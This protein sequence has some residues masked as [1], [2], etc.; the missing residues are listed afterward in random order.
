EPEPEPVA[1]T[2]TEPEPEPVAEPETEPEPVAETEPEPV[3]ETEP[4][5]GTDTE[6]E[7]GRLESARL[8]A[9]PIG[10]APTTAPR[11][12]ES[13][14][15]EDDAA[16]LAASPPDEGGQ[17]PL[18]EV[19]EPA[20][21]NEPDAV[22]DVTTSETDDILGGVPLPITALPDAEGGCAQVYVVG[23]VKRC[24][25]CG[26]ETRVIAG[27]LVN[28]PS[29]VE[30]DPSQS[31]P[32][33]RNRRKASRT[34]APKFRF[35]P[36]PMV[37]GPLITR[38][39]DDWYDRFEVGRLAEREMDEEYRFTGEGA[40]LTNGCRHCD[41]MLRTNPILDGFEEVIGTHRD[42]EP[43]VF[44]VV[45][46]PVDALPGTDVVLPGDPNFVGSRMG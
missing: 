11:L 19:A 24:Y 32:L 40:G 37:I 25:S 26:D 22:D 3:A 27:V 17:S 21:G 46:L 20:G 31:Q 41:A 36:L 33:H 13:P 39:D 12:V 45:D 18:A 8:A 10:G 7:A 23:M 5:A 44:A 4:E 30:E 15:A 6:E 9:T 38:L 42:Y 43:F 1:E 14:P 35:V 28:A 29:P 16:N 34:R 2:E